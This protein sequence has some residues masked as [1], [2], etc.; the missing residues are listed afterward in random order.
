[1]TD[2][3]FREAHQPLQVPSSL[4]AANNLSDKVLFALADLDCASAEQIIQHIE[5]LNTGAE[6]KPLIA[7]V[8]SI[9]TEWYQQGRI[10]A[11]EKTATWCI[12]CIRSRSPMTAQWTRKN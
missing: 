12:T 11:I 8:R 10:A 2:E 9:L 4:E 5:E 3:Q 1:M 7:G 6:S